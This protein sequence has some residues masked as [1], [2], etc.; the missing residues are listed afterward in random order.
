MDSRTR[1]EDCI[2]VLSKRLE[3]LALRVSELANLRDR[4]N[5]AEFEVLGSEH[6]ANGAVYEAGEL[7]AINANMD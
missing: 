2:F 6:N 5:K 7:P 1:L 3:E 4:V